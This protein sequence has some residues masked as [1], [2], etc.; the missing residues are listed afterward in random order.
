MPE[1]RL[2]PLH[3]RRVAEHAIPYPF[4]EDQL[5]I[6]ARLTFFR[7]AARPPSRADHGDTR[8]YEARGASAPGQRTAASRLLRR[9]MPPAVCGMGGDSEE[10]LDPAQIAIRVW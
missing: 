9:V 2:I 6:P 1:H 8:T 4:A 5:V 3:E 7:S 10:L